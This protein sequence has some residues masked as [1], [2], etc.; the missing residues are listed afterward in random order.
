[1]NTKALMVSSSFFMGVLGV[2]FSFL[3]QEVLSYVGATPNN[4]VP[5]FIQVL[6][7]LYIAFAMINWTVRT[8]LIGGIYYRPV[9]MGNFIHFFIG[10]LALVKGIRGVQA[11]TTLLAVLIIYLVFAILFGIVLFTHPLKSDG[12]KRS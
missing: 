8:N 6:G 12:A 11:S 5:L 9:T 1:M 10:D 4:I 2:L 7:G 3:P